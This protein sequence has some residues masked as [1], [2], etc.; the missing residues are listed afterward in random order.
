M[1]VCRLFRNS[2]DGHDTYTA[3]D[4]GLLEVDFHYEVDGFGSDTANIKTADVELEWNPQSIRYQAG[5]TITANSIGL[6]AY[7]GP[8]LLVDNSHKLKVTLFFIKASR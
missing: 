3:L 7:A 8:G 1:L 6:R 4:A 5:D 2:T